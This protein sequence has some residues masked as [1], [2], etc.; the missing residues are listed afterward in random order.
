MSSGD[1]RRPWLPAGFKGLR[2]SPVYLAILALSLAGAFAGPGDTLTNAS[3]G[4]A[5]AATTEE[6]LRSYL[7]LQDQ[8]HDLQ[9]RLD[10]SRKEAEVA[11]ERTSELLAGRL[12]ALEQS[13]A[14]QRSR[15]FELMQSSNRVMLVA[16]GVFA[17]VGFLAVVMMGY[18]QWRT[19]NRLA[20]ITSVPATHLLGPGTPL[21][22]LEP[23]RR[24]EPWPPA[25]PSARTRAWLAPCNNWTER[26][27]ELEHSAHPGDDINPAPVV[28]V[29]AHSPGN[30]NGHR[31]AT[32]PAKGEPL[33]SR[34]PFL[35]GR[36]Q[37]LLNMDKAEEALASF[38]EALSLEPGHGEAL[39]KR[40][41][42]LERLGRTEAAIQ[43]YDRAIA[44]DSSLTVAYLYREAFTIAWIATPKRLI[45]TKKRCAPKS[46]RS[47]L[48]QERGLFREERIL[49]PSPLF[50]EA[51][52]RPSASPNR[53]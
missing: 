8:L 28:D 34:I 19:I 53:T 14:P 41:Q 25:P 20:E 10:N 38:E 36:G 32:A 44:A 46:R 24:N 48:P 7:R 47:P 16:A 2:F 39:V 13:L 51:T 27:L 18:F 26:I 11:A 4:G 1:D 6:T 9:Q 40:G 17:G 31:A 35:L 3:P 50:P 15:E 29:S 43:S 23:E 52:L 42:A 5:E 33:D 45:A 22:G 21:S 37:S 12:Q 30:G 49:L